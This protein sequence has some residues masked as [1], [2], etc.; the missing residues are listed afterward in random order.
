MVL[1]IYTVCSTQFP[2]D[3]RLFKA[4]PLW[5]MMDTQLYRAQAI[6]NTGMKAT[7]WLPNKPFKIT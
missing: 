4:L 1:C 5:M 3:T 6:L 2:N 7:A